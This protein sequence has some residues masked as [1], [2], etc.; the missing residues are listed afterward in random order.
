MPCGFGVRDHMMFVI[1]FKMESFVGTKPL[2]FIWSG[3][4]RLNNKL[5]SVQEQYLK[6]LE[7]LLRDHNI[8]QR[9]QKASK[10]TQHKSIVKEETDKIENEKRQYMA[11]SEKKCRRIKLGSIPFSDEAALW[12]RCRKVY[13]FILKYHVG[14]IRN[15]ANLKCAARRCGIERALS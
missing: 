11:H 3:A 4:H 13:H 7:K 5:P 14:K 2:C 9:I 12:I 15:I 6:S 10:S 8:P 1:D